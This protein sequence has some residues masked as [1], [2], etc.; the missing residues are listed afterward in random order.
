MLGPGPRCAGSG[1]PSTEFG[2][3]YRGPASVIAMALATHQVGH[4]VQAT[5]GSHNCK[6]FANGSDISGPYGTGLDATA[7]VR[8]VERTPQNRA[9]WVQMDGS[10]VS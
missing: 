2:L 1:S 5:P 10:R 8:F 9:G 3:G 6:P 4:A 7:I